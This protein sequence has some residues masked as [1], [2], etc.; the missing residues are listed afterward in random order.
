M[1]GLGGGAN[2]ASFAS[3]ARFVPTGEPCAL[4]ERYTGTSSS[5]QGS[6]LCTTA[7]KLRYEDAGRVPSQ[8][9]GACHECTAAKGSDIEGYSPDSTYSERCP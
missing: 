6:S 9:K 8:P 2:G 1:A 3:R 4:V 7:A 5:S